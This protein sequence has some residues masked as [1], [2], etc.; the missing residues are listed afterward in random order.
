[1]KNPQTDVSQGLN[2]MILWLGLVFDSKF[3]RKVGGHLTPTYRKYGHLV[4]P[5]GKNAEAM[6]EVLAL[7]KGIPGKRSPWRVVKGQTIHL[8]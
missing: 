5:R 3:R 7:D 4:V 6:W 1:M 8:W 2:F